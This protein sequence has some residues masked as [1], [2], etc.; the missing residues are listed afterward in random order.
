[1]GLIAM[2]EKVIELHKA[3]C[4]N[5]QLWSRAIGELIFKPFGLYDAQNSKYFSLSKKWVEDKITKHNP[6][7]G[8]DQFYL[9]KA[10]R[11]YLVVNFNVIPVMD[12]PTLLPMESTPTRA[13]ALAQHPSAGINDT[14]ERLDIGGGFIDPFDFDSTNPKVQTDGLV[15]TDIPNFK[16]SIHSMAGMSSAAYA[17]QLQTMD[18][19]SAI[20][21]IIPRKN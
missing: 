10:N 13:G 5:D 20:D 11:P 9:P 6:T 2:L 12:A 4:S 8:H 18:L 17:E 3:G 19:P 14:G 7:I 15:E 16:F 21:S 1:M